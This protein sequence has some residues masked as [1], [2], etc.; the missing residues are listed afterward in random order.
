MREG[1]DLEQRGRGCVFGD[2]APEECSPSCSDRLREG[3]REEKMSNRPRVK[4][5]LVYLSIRRQKGE[6][7]HLQKQR[8]RL[9]ILQRGKRFPFCSERLCS[10]PKTIPEREGRLKA[11]VI[12]VTRADLFSQ[13][14]P[15]LWRGWTCRLRATPRSQRRRV[16]PASGRRKKD[17]Q[18]AGQ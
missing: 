1:L 8:E 18:D 12:G 15:R 2:A 17:R 13:P 7:V 11:R 9:L 16:R 10:R 5:Q 3:S 14:A 6:V 4:Y